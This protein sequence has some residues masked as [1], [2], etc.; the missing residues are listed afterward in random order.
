MSF[1][2]SKLGGPALTRTCVR[3]IVL[4][5]GA[6]GTVPA[7]E[8][9][10]FPPTPF[11]VDVTRPPYSA[12][13]DGTTDDTAAIQRALNENVGRHRAIFFPAGTYLITQTLTWPKRWEGHD[14]WGHTTLVGESRDRSVLRLREG[15]FPS[16]KQG[17]ALMWCGGFGSADWFHNYIEDLTFEVGADNAGGTGLQFYSNNSGAVRNCRFVA[18]GG[19]GLSGLDLAHRDMNGPL[20]VQNCEVVGFRRGVRTGHAVN[21]QTFEHLTLRGQLEVGFDNEGQSLAI[22]HLTSENAVP[23]LRSYGAVCLLDARLT[24]SGDARSHPALVS[25]NGGRIFLRDVSATGY[26]RTLASVESPDSGAAYRLTAEAQPGTVGPVIAEHA[27]RPACQPFG[28]PDRSLRL[29]I[30]DTP[31]TPEEDPETWAVVDRFGADPSG[32]AD[33][34]A[35]LQ[36][37]IDSGATTVFLP[38]SYNLRSTVV[39][40]GRVRR[41]RGLGGMINYGKGI[42]PDLRIADAEAPTVFVEHLAHVG[43]GLEVASRRTVVLRSVSDC[44]LTF[45]PESAGGDLFLEDVVTHGL[46][47]AN[48]RTWAR[49]LNVENEGT[50]LAN[51]GSDLWI[52]GYKTERGGTLLRS[53]GGGRTE[54]FG[55]FSYTTTAGKLAP[56]FINRDSAVFACF[57]EVCF[58]GDPFRTL[59]EECRRGETRSVMR[60]SGHTWP[61]SSHLP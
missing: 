21:S 50:H 2:L 18:A 19:S 43:G 44:D 57:S 7:L 38:G 33:S 49:Q 14:N 22:R 61:Y 10:R 36:R 45:T 48:R 60:D 23:A 17:G 4:L 28:G 8:A 26:L 20:L 37:A 5:L 42:R 39:I 6:P 32:N 1:G 11:V 12:S 52:L 34:S 59:I 25:Y 41:I 53:T 46:K 24:G 13:G 56:M 40:R 55:N 30:R 58:N 54:I 9:A 29:P 3:L 51:E 31:A 16:A 27:S 15:T 47:L 35:A